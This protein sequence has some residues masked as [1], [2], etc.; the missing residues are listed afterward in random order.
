MN[1]L[2]LVFHDKSLFNRKQV[3]VKQSLIFYMMALL[4]H[5]E[6]WKS[7]EPLLENINLDW[8]QT[9]KICFNNQIL[10]LV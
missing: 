6:F 7:H 3:A 1:N 9:K 8:T 5:L 2:K 10:N 4:A